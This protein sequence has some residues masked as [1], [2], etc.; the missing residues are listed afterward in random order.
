[1]CACAQIIEALHAFTQR[2][3]GE[4]KAQA[5]AQRQAGGGDAATLYFVDP[6]GDIIIEFDEEMSPEDIT[7][8]IA[9]QILNY[10]RQHGG[11]R[12]PSPP[13]LACALPASCTC[14]PAAGCCSLQ[15]S[16]CAPCCAWR[17][18]CRWGRLIWSMMDRAG[19]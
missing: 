4:G 6:A 12:A 14:P 17:A 1:M 9:E 3:K 7:S 16:A 5:P 18:C 15:L 19:L 10:K 13:L 11:A 8:A 2:L